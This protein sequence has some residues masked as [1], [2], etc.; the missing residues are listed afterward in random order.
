MFTNLVG[1]HV[2][3]KQNASQQIYFPISPPAVNTTTEGVA[4]FISSGNVGDSFTLV[5]IYNNTINPNGSN[6]PPDKDLV[7]GT[8]FNISN[9]SAGIGINQNVW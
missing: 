7:Y 6:P 2:V 3:I 5:C 9:L 8:D 1:A 4:G